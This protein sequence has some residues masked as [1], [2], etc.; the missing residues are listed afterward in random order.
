MLMAS[1]TFFLSALVI[2]IAGTFLTHFADQIAETT[3]LGRLLIGSILLA[4]ATSLPEIVVDI[5][6]VRHGWVNLA[7]GDL[8]GSSL[9]NLLILASIDVCMRPS[10]KV[11]SHLAHRHVLSGLFSLMMTAV[12]GLALADGRFLT[13]HEYSHVSYGL[14]LVLMTYVWGMRLVFND[15][16]A[17]RLE[18][19]ASHAPSGS[20]QQSGWALAGFG[21][22]TV[23]IVL[24]GPFLST[25]AAELADLTGLG[26]TFVG[27]TLVA[28]STSLPELVSTIAAVRLGAPDLAIGNIFGSN[29]FNMLILLPLDALYD[30]PM[31]RH[32]GPENLIT[33]LATLLATSAAIIGLAYRPP[34]RLALLDPGGGLI[35]LIVLAALWLVYSST[36]H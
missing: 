31:L 30:G 1:L 5:S 7:V 12:M 17:S 25:S 26:K 3:G 29:S 23:V 36:R 2:I 11:F 34:R 24:S 33:C 4:S 15:Q 8:L 19:A 18:V 14:W 35:V 9:F 21:V 27:T 28:C 32:V 16:R 22:C 6:A 20:P 10:C 13:Q